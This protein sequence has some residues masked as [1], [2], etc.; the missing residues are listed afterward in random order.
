MLYNCKLGLYCL[1]IWHFCVCSYLTWNT[2]EA[3]SFIV[4]IHSFV[5]GG[6]LIWKHTLKFNMTF[7]V[8]GLTVFLEKIASLILLEHTLLWHFIT[9]LFEEACDSGP[10]SLASTCRGVIVKNTTTTTTKLREFFAQWVLHHFKSV[11][12][13]AFLLNFVLVNRDILISVGAHYANL[14]L[15]AEECVCQHIQ[16]IEPALLLHKSVCNTCDGS[17]TTWI[18]HLALCNW[19]CNWICGLENIPVPY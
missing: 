8:W 17:S 2:T 16:S 7:S 5:C 13:Q 15:P 14:H 11:G 10:E 9:L 3:E 6:Q 1:S 19:A 18:V 4:A 12:A